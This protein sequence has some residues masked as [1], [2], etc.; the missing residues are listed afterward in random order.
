MTSPWLAYGVRLSVS[1][2]TY[3]L[4]HGYFG[5]CNYLVL[6]IFNLH[7]I[8]PPVHAL[9]ACTG[10]LQYFLYSRHYLHRIYIQHCCLVRFYCKSGLGPSDWLK[11]FSMRSLQVHWLV[12]F[13]WAWRVRIML[14]RISRF[15]FLQDVTIVLSVCRKHVVSFWR[16]SKL[17]KCFEFLRRSQSSLSTLIM[18][19]SV[20]A[21]VVLDCLVGSLVC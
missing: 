3:L 21:R 11:H 4:Y 19:C 13:G 1:T 2:S 8:R 6:I 7:L 9:N 15:R 14:R 16:S 20:L 12:R 18:F 10:S 17:W 5:I